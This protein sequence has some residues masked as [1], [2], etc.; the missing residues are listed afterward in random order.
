MH[1]KHSLFLFRIVLNKQ[2]FQIAVML[3]I[4]KTT[5][6]KQPLSVTERRIRDLPLHTLQLDVDEDC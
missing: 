4:N 6:R 5:N 2:R 1:L 3:I